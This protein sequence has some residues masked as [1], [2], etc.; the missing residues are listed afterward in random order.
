MAKDVVCGKE[1]NE[2]QAR[3]ETSQT[4]HGA[5]EVDPN[6]GTRIFHD[7]A[8]MYFCGLDCR[9]KFLASPETYKS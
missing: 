6:Q 9:T 8:W 3:A 5:A 7:G 1:I 4:A 2:D